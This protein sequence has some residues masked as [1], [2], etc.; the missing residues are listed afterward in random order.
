FWSPDGRYIAFFADA[1]LKK[2]EAGGGPVETLCDA[3][4]GKGGTW[5][6]EGEILFST[7]ALGRVQRMADT[8]GSPSEAPHSVDTRMFFPVF[9]P[10]GRSYLVRGGWTPDAANAGIWLCSTTS[11]GARRIL[12]DFSSPGFAEP[13]PGSRVGHVLFTRGGSL[14]A[15]PF[16]TKRLE[17]AGDPF[18][19]A[20]QA[21]GPWTCGPLLLA[22]VS[23]KRAGWQYVW[24]DRQGRTLAAFGEAGPTVAVSSDGT[25][26]VGGV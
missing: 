16:D 14:M 26:L 19:V 10:D 20:Q 22:Y 17:P 15:L 4:G 21:T 7:D 18:P 25:Q 6:R 11:A 2:V 24:R 12:P 1:T 8:G 23:S 3:Q 13:A 5:N 9:L